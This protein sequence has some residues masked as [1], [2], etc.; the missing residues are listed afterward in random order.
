MDIRVTIQGITPLI[1]HAFTEED[2]I[3]ATEGK[4]KSAAAV[5]RGSPEEQAEKHLHKGSNGEAVIPQPMV[6]SCIMAGGSFFKMGR[7]K[8]TTQRSSLIPAAIAVEGVT[9]PIVSEGGWS[10]DT[11]PV[12]IPATGGRILRH[13]PIFHDWRVTFDVVLDES[14]M[15]ADLLRD[16]VDAAGSKCGLGDF[17]PATKGPYGRFK[18][19]VWQ[20][21]KKPKLKVA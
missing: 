6:L 18:V 13:R 9:F 15:H 8:I 17:R 5:N 11:R 3:T 14:E 12:R 10:V 21:A 4:R 2:Q 19:I 7:S 20:A 16:V 1:L